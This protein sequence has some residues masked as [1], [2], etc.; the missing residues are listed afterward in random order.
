V[1]PESTI[2]LPPKPLTFE[3]GGKLRF[4]PTAQLAAMSRALAAMQPIDEPME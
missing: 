4:S 2:A 3:S 1:P